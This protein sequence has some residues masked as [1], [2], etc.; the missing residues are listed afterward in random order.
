MA[1]LGTGPATAAT[2]TADLTGP[3]TPNDLAQA[4]AGEGV[5]VSNVS[6]TGD[7]RAAGTFAET[8]ATVFGFDSGVI[9]SSGEVA[10]IVGPN[11]QDGTTTPFGTA[12]DPD[13]DALAGFDT[14]DAAVLSFDFVPDAATV[15]VSYVFASEEYN[16]YANSQFN[17]TFAFFVNGQNCATVGGDPV[18]INTINGGDPLGTDAVRPELYRNNDLDDG[19]PTI[20]TEADGLTV[21]LVCEAAVNEGVTNT[22]KLAIA[23][24]SDE[25]LDSWVV[26]SASGITTEKPEI[27]NDAID[28]DG[29]GLVD[30]DDP[31]CAVTGPA[32]TATT[33]TG[34][35]SVQYSDPL[36]VSG[37]LT[38]TDADPDAPVSGKDLLFTLGSQST[39]AGPTDAA[40]SAAGSIT[41]SQ[42]P[43]LYDLT[44]S[45]AGDAG[46]AASSDKDSVA[47]AK[48]DTSLAYTGDTLVAPMASTTLAA[49]LGE[50]DSSL[51][52]LSNKTID[53]TVTDSS[54]AQ[55][56]FSAT[57]NAAG[58]ASTTVPLASGVYSVRA[59]F[60]GDD[61]YLESATG[62][63]TLVTVQEAAAKVTGGGWTSISTGRTS[64]GFNVIPEA[65]GFKG[66]FQLRAKADKSRFH[67]N[68]ATGLVVSGNNAMWTGTGKWNGEEGYSF[69]VWV[70]DNG[71]SGGK[72][73]DTI[74]VVIKD[75]SGAVV[76]TTGSTAVALKG[77]NITIH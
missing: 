41:V 74:K 33:Y 35:T 24:G 22:M 70:V 2:T 67:G 42:V 51:G 29:D 40:G 12:G 60:A 77:G 46:F 63:D 28:N 21:G 34:A 56:S 20:N 3:L 7:E 59:E 72:K 44:T 58:V 15:Y 31:D 30:G 9:L 6:Y 48:E 52:D 19:G 23:D 11:D 73:G 75:P 50:L 65:T 76:F 18:S 37:V 68:T 36:G 27:C 49:T 66:Q 45:F 25:V 62:L 53:F 10:S 64:F 71:S 4:L 39:T 43:A 26:L 14:F 16:E 32:A 17:D 1:V 5:V 55:Q 57:T 13:L 38:D 47:V 8:D 54:M 69:Q 61:Y